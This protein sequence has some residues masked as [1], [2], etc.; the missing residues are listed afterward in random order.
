VCVADIN[1]K[2]RNSIVEKVGVIKAKDKQAI[3]I[4]MNYKG[5]K[6]VINNSKEV[7]SVFNNNENKD[8]KKNSEDK[9]TISKNR[10]DLGV[11]KVNNSNNKKKPSKV[12]ISKSN[13]KDYTKASNNSKEVSVVKGDKNISR[14]ESC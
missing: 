7:F 9:N 13:D 2:K 12:N 6:E 11:S 4:V 1:V 5:G 3:S 14:K 8:Y 10:G